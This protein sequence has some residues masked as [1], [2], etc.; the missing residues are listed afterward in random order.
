MENENT[1]EVIKNRSYVACLSQGMAHPIMHFRVISKALWPTLLGG[2]LLAIVAAFLPGFALRVL[3]LR[4]ID[5]IMCVLMIL[6]LNVMIRR[7][8]ELGYIP[9]M[10]PR[11]LWAL[12]PQTRLLFRP[13]WRYTLRMIGV[14]LMACF[15]ASLVSLCV[16]LPVWATMMFEALNEVHVQV[17]LDPSALPA[18]FVYI[19]AA[20]YALSILGSFLGWLLFSFPV[21]FCHG[22]ILA[23]EQ[24][25]NAAKMTE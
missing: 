21:A 6:Q 13:R 7:L 14:V 5:L 18:G 25:R 8:V 2:V 12:I 9:E 4:V 1:I 19:R 22:S 20:A 3:A 24:E 11:V 17:D 23:E 16:S 15:V 10:K